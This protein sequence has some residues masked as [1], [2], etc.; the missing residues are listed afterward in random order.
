MTGNRM[1]VLMLNLPFLSRDLIEQEASSVLPVQSCKA[2]LLMLVL[3]PVHLQLALI[4][5]QIAKA[6]TGPLKGKAP[7]QDPMESIVQAHVSMLEWHMQSR[8]FGMTAA[9]LELLQQKSVEVMESFVCTFPEKNGVKNGWK[10]EKGPQ[11]F[12]QGT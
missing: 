1:K 5:S 2:Y 11:H 12:A 8:K 7:V 6:K 10:F 9:K 4:N 3:I